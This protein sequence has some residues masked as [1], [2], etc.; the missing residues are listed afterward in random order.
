MR[1]FESIAHEREIWECIKRKT[2]P[3]KFAFAGDAAETHDELAK[4]KK[5]H[6]NITSL[7]VE[8]D[9]LQG[10]G[11]NL[12]KY[13][14]VCEI[15]PG[16]AHHT[17]TL[18]NFLSDLGYLPD[19]YL[20]LDFSRNLLDIGMGRIKEQFPSLTT[21]S[22]TWDFEKQPTDAIRRWRSDDPVLSL[23]IG[24]TLSNMASPVNVFKNIR[25][26]HT[27]GDLLLL[28]VALWNDSP[29]DEILDGYRTDV[30]RNAALE[31]LLMAGIDEDCG[32]FELTLDR[33]ERSVYG[34]F[35]FHEEFELSYD[36]ESLRFEPGSSITC[37]RSKRF[38][39]NEVRSILKEANWRVT[40]SLIS[41]QN[42]YG[43]YLCKIDS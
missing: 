29:T 23:F 27:D 26:S 38:I 9:I 13:N 28:E 33:N 34:E 14:Q 37:F 20:A 42:T 5:Y 39:D 10:M 3:L 6:E 1:G 22:E 25:D 19:D 32:C 43:A 24:S 8:K 7:Q 15:G 40:N 35:V 4:S 18:L 12:Q 30:F 41:S 16:N 36:G 21:D 17:I 31:P 2:V 11:S